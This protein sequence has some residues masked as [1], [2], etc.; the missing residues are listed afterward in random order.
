MSNMDFSKLGYKHYEELSNEEMQW[1]YDKI[2]EQWR[3][4]L[5]LNAP[6]LVLE[7]DYFI[8]KRNVFEV[9]SRCNKRELYHY[10]F[11]N[12]KEV[13][14]YKVIAIKCFWIMTL[15]PFMVTNSNSEIY[16]CPNEMFSLFLILETIEEVMAKFFPDKEFSYPSEA[17][18]RDLLYKFKFCSLSREA[19]IA[20]VE[21]LADTYGVGISHILDNYETIK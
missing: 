2:V 8:H 20:L 15:K 14:E 6:D 13:T 21:T 11:H 12:L 9:I 1:A 5:S 7:K 19:M 17:R 4:F 16:N 18:M 10:V 3:K